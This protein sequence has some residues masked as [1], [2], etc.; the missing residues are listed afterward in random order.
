VRS[1]RPTLVVVCAATAVLMFQVAAPNVALPEIA[2][3]VG[4]SFTDLQWVLSG[5]TLAL[6]V[7]MLT[8]GSL[9][10]RP[11]R[12]RLFVFGLG[13]LGL[14]SLLCA[15]APSAEALI[16]ARVLQG[17]GAGVV[18]PSALALLVFEHDG[19]GRRRA[20]G[21]WGAV[22]GLAY[23]LGPLVAGALVD[24]LSWRAIF[25]ASAVACG[26]I[27]LAG[28]R[29]LV[30]SSDPAAPRVDWAGV[31]LLSLSL[32]LLVFAIL[33]GN[34]LGWGTPAIVGLLAGGAALLVAFVAVERAGRHLMIDLALFRNRTFTGAS[35]AI[36][37]ASACSFGLFTYL[38]LFLLN[39]QGRRPV[40]AGAL[41]VPLAG[42]SFVTSAVAGRVRGRLPL[43]AAIVGGFG[44]QLAGLLALRGLSQD[45]TFA[46]LAPGLLL[47]GA[48]IGLINPLATFAGVGVLPPAHGGL[49]SALN[50]TARQL[51][52]A[53]GIAV[54]GAVLQA[55][56]RGDLGAAAAAGGAQRDRVLDALADGDLAGALRL[57]PAGGRDALRA[58]YDTA[59][60]GAMDE[61]LLVAAGVAA[62]G[63]LLSLAL[64]HTRD[65]WSPVPLEA[66]P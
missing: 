11:G 44:L 24:T 32:F 45:T 5:Y 23:A 29:Q 47:A 36:G 1:T 14:A 66:R 65:L 9:A 6:A 31:A 53:V 21:V 40:E 51:G 64:V 13:L 59:Y 3:D 49:E 39:V 26:A 22:V 18:F 4:A 48:G 63:A 37:L 62:A 2:R 55:R 35:L 43:R 12:R 41:L 56:L 60:S 46:Q 8:A 10:D 28:T 61:L 7:L 34:A 52:L 54:L 19:R 30:E 42:M 27:A 33:R 17:L 25:V 15:I 50:S 20:L 38:T 58:A 16:L 57:V